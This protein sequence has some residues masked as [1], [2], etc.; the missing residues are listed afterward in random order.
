MKFLFSIILML[1]AGIFTHASCQETL[2]HQMRQ[3][4]DY[5]FTDEVSE[6]QPIWRFSTAPVSTETFV[7]TVYDRTDSAFVTENGIFAVFKKFDGKFKLCSAETRQW[8]VNFDT[9]V[10][11]L[12]DSVATVLSNLNGY[13]KY[14]EKKEIFSFGFMS[15][16]DVSV[17]KAIFDNDTINDIRL[18]C[19]SSEF[20]FRLVQD[21]DTVVSPVEK[22]TEYLW[23][24]KSSCFPVV[25][26]IESARVYADD[27]LSVTSKTLLAE[28]SVIDKLIESESHGKGAE[29]IYLSDGPDRL[30]DGLDLQFN[31][32]N[33]NELEIKFR[34]ENG[35]DYSVSFDVFNA[36][37]QRLAQTVNAT[38]TSG[39]ASVRVRLLSN[40][41]GAYF[42]RVTVNDSFQTFKVT[43]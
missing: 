10:S 26:K 18:V 13:G 21:Y 37:G 2:T 27:T 20:G 36:L 1:M 42:V 25:R 24:S 14:C 30:P 15:V 41:S 29:N 32:V 39:E 22:T 7:T 17:G 23:F 38:C 40:Q 16:R 28:S 4:E 8:Y 31:I 43:Q 35:N 11:V 33:P 34:D 6:N 9:T 3:V 5:E 19:R 12:P